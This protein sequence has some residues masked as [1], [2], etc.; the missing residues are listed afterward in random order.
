MCLVASTLSFRMK[1]EQTGDS[2]LKSS[3]RTIIEWGVLIGVI[4][5]LYVTGWHTQVIGTMQRGLLAT[6]LIKPGIPSLT[7]EFP[8]ASM[9]FYFAD[10][11]GRVV[12][13]AEFEGNV[14][15]LNVWATW[16]PPCIAEMPSIQTLY[17]EMKSVDNIS[18]VLVTMD[19]EFEK[20][21]Q[22]MERRGYSMPI[23]HYRT[24]SR[25]TYDSTVIPTTYVITKDGRLALEKRGLARY[26]TPEFK[27]FLLELAEL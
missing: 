13:L 10:E 16:C 15:F 18:F 6:G 1:N 26:D 21:G 3:K 9:D 4:V 17:N 11:N 24:R 7:E 27:D 2:N 22:F 23:Y 8:P 12:S 20:A 5:L 25:Q 14:V 19:E